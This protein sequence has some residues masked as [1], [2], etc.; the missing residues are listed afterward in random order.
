MAGASTDY[1]EIMAIKDTMA[2]WK[3]ALCLP[4]ITVPQVV[5]IGWLLNLA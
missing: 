2:S 4:L 3:I 5:V 1:T